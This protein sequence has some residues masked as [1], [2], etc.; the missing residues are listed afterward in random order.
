MKSTLRRALFWLVALSLG[1]MMACG[2]PEP[3]PGTCNSD[4]DCDTG[5]VCK[6]GTCRRLC[7]D[8]EDCVDQAICEKGLCP[9]E[10]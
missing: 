7:N 8:N 3:A 6:T 1:L 2:T 10:K 4:F 5:V 9:V